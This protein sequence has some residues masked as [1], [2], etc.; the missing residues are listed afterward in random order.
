[1]TLRDVIDHLAP[2]EKVTNAQGFQLE[3]GQSGPT[4]KQKVR[5]VLRARRTST[6]ARELAEGSLERVDEAVAALARSAYRSGSAS[7]HVGA[8]MNEIRNLK[9]YVDAL[10]GELLE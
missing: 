3:E 6:A 1:E 2:D 5:Y 8:R 4:Q 7:T 9:R 10:L